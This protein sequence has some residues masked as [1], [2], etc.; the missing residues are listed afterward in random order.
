VNSLFLN[1][2]QIVQSEGFK[3][4]FFRLLLLTAGGLFS[5]V[6]FVLRS[7]FTVPRMVLLKKDEGVYISGSKKRA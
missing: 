6:I 1:S 2:V 5:T 4:K 3:L 7:I